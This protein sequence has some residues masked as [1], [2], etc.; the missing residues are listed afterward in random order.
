MPAEHEMDINSNASESIHGALSDMYSREKEWSEF[1]KTRSGVKGLVDAGIINIPKFFILPSEEQLMLKSSSS[2]ANS[3]Q[4]QVPVIDLEGSRGDRRN[5]VVAEIRK[6]TETWG[7]FQMVNHGIPVDVMNGL[8]ESECQF[9]DQPKEVKMEF[10]SRDPNKVFQYYSTHSRESETALWRDTI[11]CNIEAWTASPESL[12]PVCRKAL[13]SYVEHAM[14]LRDLL[15]E[16]LSEALELDHDH[17]DRIECMESSKMVCHYYPAC[18]EPDL[19]IGTPKHS[20]PYFLTILLQNCIVGLQ[21]LN[22][23]H[24]VD[25]PP[26][27]GALIAIVGDLL[28]LISNDKFK[29]PEHRV[30]ATRYGPRLSTACL[31]SPRSENKYRSYGPIVELLFDN[32]PPIY[33]ETSQGEYLRCYISNELLGSRVLTRFK[34]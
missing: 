2:D 24:W 30:L 8:L 28:Q 18:P 3:I 32:N 20:D 6:A 16:L 17:L 7:I 22:D 33:K 5:E 27:P 29:S 14:K 15:S 13:R 23:D 10:Y 11:I 21:V 1:E 25:V 31:F 9:H 34:R 26:V 19:T 12:P 4:L